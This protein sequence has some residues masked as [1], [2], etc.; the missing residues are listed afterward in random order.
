MKD[1][2]ARWG[3]FLTNRWGWRLD[4]RWWLPRVLVLAVAGAGAVG[5][6]DWRGHRPA[7]PPGR[8]AHLCRMPTGAGTPLA[9]LLPDGG[10]D[11]EERTKALIGQ[12]PQT[13]VIRVDGRSA[14]TFTSVRRQGEL[15]LTAEGAKHPQAR[16][17]DIAGLGTSWPG[18][19]AVAASCLGGK[20]TSNDY[21][22][23]EVTAGEA[24]RASGDGGRA[25]LEELT[26]AALVEARKDRCS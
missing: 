4:S 26:R 14:I 12:D 20:Y 21:V 15:A 5:Y 24:A 8:A 17:F 22:Q 2:A 19:A 6:L 11:V 25:D 7:D 13:C 9:R 18:G 1:L 23:L 10:Q 3:R 16:G